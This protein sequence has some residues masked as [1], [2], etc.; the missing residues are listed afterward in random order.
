ML[1]KT[2]GYQAYQMRVYAIPINRKERIDRKE[3]LSSP[4]LRSLRSLRLNSPDC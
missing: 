4:F 2:I 3:S 1:H